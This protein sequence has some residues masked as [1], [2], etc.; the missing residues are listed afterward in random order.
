MAQNFRCESSFHSIRSAGFKA[1]GTDVAHT[2]RPPQRANAMR[3]HAVGGR[4]FTGL[5]RVCWELNPVTKADGATKF[6]SGCKPPSQSARCLRF[7]RHVDIGFD[8]ITFGQRTRRT[9]R[10]RTPWSR[11]ET[12]TWTR[13][14]ARPG[15]S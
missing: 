1:G 6:L 4:I 12:S 15:L 14:S 7:A 9:L 3:Y 2:V 5:T 8:K 10:R 11:P 13:T